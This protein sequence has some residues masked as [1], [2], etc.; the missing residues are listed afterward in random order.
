LKYDRSPA[1]YS[2]AHDRHQEAVLRTGLPT[3]T[4][5]EA[6]DTACTIHFAALGHEP[7]P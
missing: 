5:Q 2:A 1:G 3:G 6:L 7:G 4:P